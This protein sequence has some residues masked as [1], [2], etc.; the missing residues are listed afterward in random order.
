M[1]SR[2][3]VIIIFLLCVIRTPLLAVIEDKNDEHNLKAI[4]ELEDRLNKTKDQNEK[5]EILKEFALVN[6]REKQDLPYIYRLYNKAIKLENNDTEELAIRQLTKY[7]Y[8]IGEA[9]S[10]TFYALRSDSLAEKRN[11]YSDYFYDIQ[12][13]YSQFLLWQGE[14]EK[15]ADLNIRIYNKAKELNNKNGII[16]CCETLGLIHQRIGQDSISIR[17]F[18]EGIDLLKSA[19]DVEYRYLMQFLNNI[20]ESEINIHHF[21]DALDHLQE[22]DVLFSRIK[23]GDFGDDLTFPFG[24]C[25]LLME[26]YYVNIFI[27]QDDRANAVKHFRKAAQYDKEVDDEYV[28]YYHT[29]TKANYYK[30]IKEYGLALEYI[31]QA[32]KT[33]PTVESMKMKAEIMTFLGH[34]EEAADIYKEALNMNEN[35][36]NASFLRQLTQ[37]N[38]LHDMNKLQLKIKELQVTELQYEANR[39]KMR[40]IWL[41]IMI[42]VIFL[43]ISIYVYLHTNKLKNEL[44][45][46]KQA[47]LKS[48]K[49]LIEARDKAQES[50]KLKSLFLSNMSH[51]IRTP[52]NA[53]VGFSQLLEL[54]VQT[55]DEQKEYTHI[56]IEN[57]ELLLNLVNDILDISRLESERYRFTFELQ[58]VE[59]CCKNALASI[60]HRVKKNVEIVFKPQ[61]KDLMIYTDKMRL[62]QILINLLGNAAKFTNKGF[63][64]LAYELDEEE[65]FVKFIVTDS[66]CGIPKDK[67]DSIFERFEKLNEC[68]QGTG[69]GLSICEI[70]ANQFHGKVILDKTYT[71]GARFIFYH[72][73]DI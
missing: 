6:G 33:D 49:D 47:L 34:P 30:Y 64:E 17:Y 46:D 1:K 67:Q 31:N 37:L 11:H 26:C 16:C 61:D 18:N 23:N 13:F 69:L 35:I 55:N 58:N 51:E 3:L 39:Q 2:V 42:L 54:D 27:L 73:L 65:K 44:Q 71:G 72:S 63:I 40:H 20:I 28:E 57:S 68:V 48:E 36:N 50:E 45:K 52:L 12:T 41:I 10:V 53:I 15:A 59:E 21:T 9:D 62:Q 29:I 5:L 4:K 70:I 19:K 60:H 24:R 38:S 66:G 7:Y 25:Y 22:L 56:I 43:I 8:N 14:F 32:L